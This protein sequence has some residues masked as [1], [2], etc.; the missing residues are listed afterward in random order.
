MS[1]VS[2]FSVDNKKIGDANLN[3]DIFGLK[4]KPYLLHEVVKMQLANKRAGTHSTKTRAEVH[5]SDAKPWK[6]KGTGRARAGSKTSPL[7]RKGGVIFGPKPRDYSYTMP[8]K[9]VK[10]ALKNALSAKLQ[11]GV[12]SVLDTVS[13]DGK[14]KSA[15]KFLKSFNLDN[16][17]L[18][19]YKEISDETVL[20]FRNLQ[21]VKLLSV[22]GLN[23]YDVINAKSIFFVKDALDAV[24]KE[25]F[26]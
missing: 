18:V 12:I 22:A 11:D 3:S 19:V 24:E 14:T 16:K 20:S 26:V 4:V 6:Q 2:I 7:W 15:K 10:L 17:V 23:V 9:K 13:M 21:E 25:L 5:G 1:V 8:K